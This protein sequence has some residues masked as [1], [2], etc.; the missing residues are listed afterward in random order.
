MSQDNLLAKY[1][2][3]KRNI[4]RQFGSKTSK[5]QKKYHK[6]IYSKW[7]RTR[8]N[9]TRQ[10]TVNSKEPEELLQNNL[11]AKHQK[12][13][14]ILQDNSPQIPKIRRTTTRQFTNKILKEQKK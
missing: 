6:T 2:R 10:F 1:Q 5:N 4:T 12:T 13:K 11:L 9:T 8:R 3:T 7:Q 14:K